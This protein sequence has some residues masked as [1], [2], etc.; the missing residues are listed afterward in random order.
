MK[1]ILIY[2]GDCAFCNKSVIFL[3]KMDTEDLFF[4][5]S[6]T[7]K[8]GRRLI[9]QHKMQKLTNKTLIVLIEGTPYIKTKAIYNFLRIV[10]RW[11]IVQ[12]LLRISPIVLTNFIYDMVAK[13]RLQLA[14][15]SC[16]VPDDSIRHKFKM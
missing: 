7:S 5:I 14:K 1:N 16:T 3:A 2:D 15:S 8:E 12:L 6:N 9:E 13:C 11:K 10:N 4:F